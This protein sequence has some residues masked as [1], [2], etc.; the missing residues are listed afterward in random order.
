MAWGPL[1]SL[2][3]VGESVL[4]AEKKL[5]ENL[6]PRGMI[7]GWLGPHCTNKAGI[8]FAL[9]LLSL[10]PTCWDLKACVAILGF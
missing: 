8:N 5:I 10:P 7:P 3:K 6:D 1:G 2:W 4:C 9:L